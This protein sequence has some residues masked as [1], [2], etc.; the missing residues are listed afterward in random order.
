MYESVKIKRIKKRLNKKYLEKEI[1]R[2][3]IRFKKMSYLIYFLTRNKLSQE[4]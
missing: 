2:C 1:N 4:V 3:L